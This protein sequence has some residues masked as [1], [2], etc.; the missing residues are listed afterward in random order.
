MP[1]SSYSL[2]CFPI[3]LFLVWNQDAAK[4]KAL[5][6]QEVHA[7]FTVAKR[8]RGSRGEGCAPEKGKWH[9]TSVLDSGL[10]PSLWGRSGVCVCARR[11]KS[12]RPPPVPCGWSGLE[13]SAGL[14]CT[15]PHRCE[16]SSCSDAQQQPLTSPVLPQRLHANTHY[17]TQHTYTACHIIN[18]PTYFPSV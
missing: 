12:P 2:S 14:F 7:E 1:I 15:P 17:T 10:W 11:H 9:R 16:A 13:S 8:E 18:S 5:Q 4:I 3:V 6:L